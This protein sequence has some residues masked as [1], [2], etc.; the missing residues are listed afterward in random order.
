[1]RRTLAALVAIA[2]LAAGCSEPPP[3]ATPIVPV[4]VRSNP[5]PVVPMSVLRSSFALPDGGSTYTGLTVEPGGRRLALTTEGRLVDIGSGATVWDS[6]GATGRF[7]FTDVVS[8][9]DGELAIT[10]TSDGFHLELGSGELRSHFCYEPGWFQEMQNEPIQVSWAVGLDRDAGLLYAQ[11]IT[12]E[13]AGNGAVT[14]SYIASYDRAGGTDL[15]WW[16]LPS[17]EFRAGGLV[18]LPGAGPAQLLLGSGSRL[19]RFDTEAAE[20][21]EAGDLSELGVGSIGALA[22]DAG[23]QEL[24]VLDDVAARVFVVPL[25][26]FT[27]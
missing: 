20:L 10:G 27:E 17:S 9:E 25:D 6:E 7:G 15:S 19:Y 14:G 1:M 26:R 12:I 13:E 3:A 23:T 2:P 18:V 8:L 21:R 24:L 22:I 16:Q 11:P 5:A 4:V